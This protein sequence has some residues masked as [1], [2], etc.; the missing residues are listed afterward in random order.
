ME[1]INDS[2]EDRKTRLLESRIN[3]P[4]AANEGK[5]LIRLFQVLLLFNPLSPGVK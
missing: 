3:L 4:L 5:N 2:L 1:Q